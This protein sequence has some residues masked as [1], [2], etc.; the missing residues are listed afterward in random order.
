MK[1]LTTAMLRKESAAQLQ[2]SRAKQQGDDSSASEKPADSSRSERRDPPVPDHPLA[3]K[4]K[5]E[6]FS[7]CVTCVCAVWHVSFGVDLSKVKGFRSKN[8][9]LKEDVQDYVKYELS[10]PK[11]SSAPSTGGEG[12]LASDLLNQKVDFSKF[13]EILKKW[14]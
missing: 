3:R 8:R 5:E 2:R 6:R 12:G 9:V 7:S 4:G 1:T 10:R 14:K 11:A 13:G